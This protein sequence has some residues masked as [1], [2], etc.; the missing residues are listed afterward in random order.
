MI[1]ERNSST[2]K[3]A[4][5]LPP[6]GSLALTETQLDQAGSVAA[7]QSVGKAHPIPTHSRGHS[8]QG[9]QKSPC[10]VPQEK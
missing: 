1:L 8:F 4:D 5:A 10:E 2:A 6:E 9:M 7:L 3:P